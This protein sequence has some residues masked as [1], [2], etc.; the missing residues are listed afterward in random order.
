MG[1]RDSLNGLLGKKPKAAPRKPAAKGPP[2]VKDSDRAKLIAEA[3]KV[4]RT[5]GAMV[6]DVLASAVGELQAGGVKTLRD[7]H[8]LERLMSLIQA[9]RT[10][11]RLMSGDLRRHVMLNGV[12]E[13]RDGPVPPSSAKTKVVKR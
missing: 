11:K 6:R 4:H 2:A 5:Q 12:R 1:W 10:M 13:L 9:Q 3:L 8:A 7:P